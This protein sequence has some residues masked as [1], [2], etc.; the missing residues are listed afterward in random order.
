MKNK[1][2]GIGLSKTGTTSLGAALEILGYRTK[3]FPSVRYIPHFLLHI[4]AGQLARFDAFTDIPTIPFYKELDRQFPGSRFIYTHREKEGWLKSCELYPRFNLPLQQLPLKIIKLRTAIYGTYKFD[5]EKFSAAYDRHHEDVM[6]YFR[7]KPEQLLS[8]DI[9][10][11]DEWEP[12]CSFL[13]KPVP[14]TP[15]PRRNTRSN[16][17][18]GALLKYQESY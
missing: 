3:D 5:R 7:H 9:I 11:G 8:L 18:D 15:Y 6:N 17:Y 1:I 4:K 12:L 13:N 10:G 16:N 14:K 2:F